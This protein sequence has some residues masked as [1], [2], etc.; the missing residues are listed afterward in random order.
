MC[1]CV[2][3][4]IKGSKQSDNHHGLCA[5]VWV[6]VCGCMSECDEL[7]RSK[8]MSTITASPRE[9]FVTPEAAWHSGQ[10]HGPR[11]QIA[12]V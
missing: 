3:D 12:E 1:V 6:C 5:R 8:R 9:G 7:K 2:Y 10:K 4:E 11:S